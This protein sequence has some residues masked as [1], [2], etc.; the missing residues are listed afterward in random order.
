MTTQLWTVSPENRLRVSFALGERLGPHPRLD[1]KQRTGLD[2]ATADHHW[3][4]LAA[5]LDGRQCVIQHRRCREIIR[6]MA[7]KVFLQISGISAKQPPVF[8][9]GIYFNLPPGELSS[10]QKRRYFAGTVDFFG[11]TAHEKKDHGDGGEAA[12][13]TQTFDN[14]SSSARV[15]LQSVRQVHA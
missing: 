8:V 11:K 4:R 12:S 7:V 10:E 1:Q 9:Y 15:G 14:S 2:L 5:H 13:F 3:A 6:R